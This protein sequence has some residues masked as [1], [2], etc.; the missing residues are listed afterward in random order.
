MSSFTERRQRSGDSA[1][2][3]ELLELSFPSSPTVL[4]IV[5]DTQDW[6][7]NGNSYIG[8][9]FRFTAPADS[10]GQAPRAQLEIANTGRGIT[11]DLEALLPNDTVMCRYLIT[12]RAAPD[13]IARRFL[14]PLT[15]VR[16]AGPTVTAQIGVDFLMRQQAV[17]L[18]CTP[19]TLPGNF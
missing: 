4:R 18:R 15:Q 16:A 11:Q 17:K 13:V 19:Y 10:A 3:L 8:F 2:P 7:S 5:N 12:D 14:L 9:P 6:A 1:A